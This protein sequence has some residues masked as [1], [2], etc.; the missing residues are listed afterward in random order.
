MGGRWEMQLSAQATKT[1]Q[2]ISF[3]LT[4]C[5][6]LLNNFVNVWKR[7]EGGKI[8]IEN[9]PAIFFWR[10][11]QLQVYA[12]ML[13]SPCGRHNLLLECKP[14]GCGRQASPCGRGHTVSECNVTEPP[15]V[16]LKPS[17]KLL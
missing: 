11:S 10:Y 9:R 14:E 3:I 4:L 8:V 17:F 15:L 2:A 7:E 12:H 13:R 5:I 1:W 16:F 6:L